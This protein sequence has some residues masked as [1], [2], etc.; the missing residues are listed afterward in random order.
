[1]ATATRSSITRRRRSS[2]SS[3]FP[4]SRSLVDDMAVLPVRARVYQ[5]PTPGFHREFPEAEARKPLGFA[6]LD[7]LAVRKDAAPV[8]A[9]GLH[10]L[11]AGGHAP[12]EEI[13]GGPKVRKR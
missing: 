4:A 5:A 8:P 2:M 9:Q 6:F 1:M 10:Q 3:A 7:C 12:P 11:D 13:R